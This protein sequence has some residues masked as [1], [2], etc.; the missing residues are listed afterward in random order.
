MQI[1]GNNKPAE[2]QEEQSTK[3]QTMAIK[4][5]AGSGEHA[6][7]IDYQCSRIKLMER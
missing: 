2:E 3:R 5:E 1:V 6:G 4:E 7:I